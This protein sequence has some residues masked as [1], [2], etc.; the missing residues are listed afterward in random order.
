MNQTPKS[1]KSKSQNS[2]SQKRTSQMVRTKP[3]GTDIVPWGSNYPRI[4]VITAAWHREIVGNGKL[5]IQTEFERC[6][7][8]ADNAQYFEVPG[9]LE[10]P[11]HA[12]RLAESGK[13]D[14]IIACALIVNGGIYRHEFVSTAVID[15]MMR[16]QLDCDVPVF[17]AVLTPINFHDCAE[18]QHFFEQHF[19]KKGT[20][21]AQACLQTIYSLRNM[22]EALSD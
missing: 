21:V 9:A 15:G 17:S 14:G 2:K 10:I 16:V 12:K 4:A 8:P 3:V 13:F 11:L 18:H 7:I 22:H 1:A 6:R 20:E 19:L 5:A